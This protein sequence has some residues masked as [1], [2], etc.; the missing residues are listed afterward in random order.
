MK[1]TCEG[2]IFS[3]VEGLQ[4]ATLLKMKSFIDFFQGFSLLFRNAYFK[5]QLSVA[6]FENSALSIFECNIRLRLVFLSLFLV[7]VNTMMILWVVIVD[8]TLN[9]V[10]CWFH[11]FFWLICALRCF[12][13]SPGHCIHLYI[14][15]HFLL[16]LAI[17]KHLVL[18]SES[19]DSASSLPS[20]RIWNM[21]QA[22]NS[23]V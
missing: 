17:S 9:R 19:F 10:A 23:G 20:L 22:A 18:T 16:V 7:L 15:Y 4:P 3:K 6:A 12:N 21:K 14:M 2:I 5:E 8:I 13:F 1:N 11:I